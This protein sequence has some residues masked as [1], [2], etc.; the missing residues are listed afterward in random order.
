MLTHWTD[1]VIYRPTLGITHHCTVLVIAS[2]YTMFD[3][4]PMQWRLWHVARYNPY[5]QKCAGNKQ[6]SQIIL[7]R[8][9]LWCN[10]Q[11][12]LE[13]QNQWQFRHWWWFRRWGYQSWPVWRLRG[14]VKWKALSWWGDA[15]SFFA[16]DLDSNMENKDEMNDVCNLLARTD[17]AEVDHQGTHFSAADHWLQKES[18]IFGSGIGLPFSKR[19][20]DNTMYYET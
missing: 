15:K 6:C 5:F 12:Q 16:L 18:T 13:W 14:T 2:P 9:R 11:L 3:T 17:F 10:E 4:E 8:I 7:P 20:Q 1:M 19:N